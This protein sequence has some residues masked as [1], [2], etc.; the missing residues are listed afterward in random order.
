[1]MYASNA[2]NGAMLLLA[3]RHIPPM[4]IVIAI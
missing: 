2:S 1:M 4:L 3:K